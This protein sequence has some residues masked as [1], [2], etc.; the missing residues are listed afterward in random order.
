MSSRYDSKD[1]KTSSRSNTSIVRDQFQSEVDAKDDRGV[2][3]A[4]RRPARLHTVSPTSEDCRIGSD[5][6]DDHSEFAST[7]PSSPKMVPVNQWL[8]I[9]TSVKASSISHPPLSAV[10]HRKGHARRPVLVKA[11]LGHPLKVSKAHVDPRVRL[12]HEERRRRPDRDTLEAVCLRRL[13]LPAWCA[14]SPGAQQQRMALSAPT[15]PTSLRSKQQFLRASSVG[16]SAEGSV[17]SRLN[18]PFLS[19]ARRPQRLLRW[20]GSS[21]HWRW[22]WPRPPLCAHLCKTWCQGR[23]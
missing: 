2:M 3:D 17:T 22:C 8:Q 6:D 21:D 12:L 9:R 4:H 23:C 15:S 11:K 14:D 20:Q 18:R 5:G 16:H 1:S 10:Q 13:M 19:S 7:A